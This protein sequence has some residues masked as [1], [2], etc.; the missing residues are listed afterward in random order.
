MGCV[1]CW[2]RCTDIS[3]SVTGRMEGGK[4]RA[5]FEET[6]N[7]QFFY[8]SAGPGRKPDDKDDEDGE[9]D[10]YFKKNTGADH[11]LISAAMFPITLHRDL[12]SVYAL[13]PFN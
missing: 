11:Y 3:V 10:W 13:G 2:S 4:E 1:N 7:K 8:F 12:S 9:R 5:W 6:A